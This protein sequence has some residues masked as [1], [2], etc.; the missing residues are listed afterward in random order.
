MTTSKK[1]NIFPLSVSRVSQL[2]ERNQNFKKVPFV[3]GK[4]CMCFY[5]KINILPYSFAHALRLLL[6]KIFYFLIAKIF[7]ILNN[8]KYMQKTQK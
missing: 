5:L 7:P 8:A 6:R 1:F 3:C 2:L 4:Y